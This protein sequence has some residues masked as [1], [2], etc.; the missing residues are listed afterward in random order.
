MGLSKS[1][2]FIEP[3]TV[4]YCS[5]QIVQ[6]LNSDCRRNQSCKGFGFESSLLCKNSPEPGTLGP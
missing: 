5:A 6:F 2:I 4:L 1:S 3:R